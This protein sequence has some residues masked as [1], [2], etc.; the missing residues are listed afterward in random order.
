MKMVYKLRKGS[1]GN[2]QFNRFGKT[3]YPC[4][5]SAIK[6]KRWIQ[7]S[8]DDI[9]DIYVIEKE[10][11]GIYVYWIVGCDLC[12]SG[13]QRNQ[14]IPVNTKRRKAEFLISQL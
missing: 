10:Y 12:C 11:K 5:L 6:A 3:C 1:V 7:E 13:I 8:L 9:D 2:C 14:L 4:I